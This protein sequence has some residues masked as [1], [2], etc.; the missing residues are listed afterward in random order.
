[1]TPERNREKRLARQKKYDQ[2]RYAKRR[3]YMRAYQLRW[4]TARRDE[5]IQSKGGKCVVCGSTHQLEVDHILP[6]LK[7]FNPKNVWGLKKEKREAELAKCQV[8]CKL[9]HI[10]KS[11]IDM[12]ERQDKNGTWGDKKYICGK[13][14]QNVLYKKYREHTAQAM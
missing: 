4:V 7:E 12:T 1:M 8:L 3:E 5:W 9:C 10:E 14:R 2:K 11:K 13:P 6:E